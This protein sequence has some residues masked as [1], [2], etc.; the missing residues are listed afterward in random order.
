MFWTVLIHVF[1]CFGMLIFTRQ[2]SVTRDNRGTGFTEDPIVGL[3]GNA[4]S[5]K[6]NSEADVDV[7]NKERCNRSTSSLVIGPNG[8]HRCVPRWPD[9][10]GGPIGSDILVCGGSIYDRVTGRVYTDRLP[11]SNE[12]GEIDSDPRSETVSIVNESGAVETKFRWECTSRYVGGAVDHMENPYVPSSF[13]RMRRTRNVCAKYIYRAMPK[14]RISEGAGGS[15]DCLAD[16]G[17]IRLNVPTEKEDK[18]RTDGMVT[19]PGTCSP[20]KAGGGPDSGAHAVNIARGCVKSFDTVVSTDDSET[21][22]TPLDRFPCGARGFNERNISCSV[23]IAYAGIGLSEFGRRLVGR[24][25][26]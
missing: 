25:L 18:M 1:F 15:C 20:C 11:P 6:G 5:A 10:F 23:A 14:I 17:K 12:I 22:E 9:L 2:P 26:W 3:P 19:L 21:F 24:A 16:H 7:N 8:K 4:K 13:D